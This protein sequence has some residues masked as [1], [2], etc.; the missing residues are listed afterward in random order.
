MHPDT[1]EELDV[2]HVRAGAGWP[3][4]VPTTT[5]AEPGDRVHI[6]AVAP[7]TGELHSIDSD[8]LRHVPESD[9]PGVIVKPRSLTV[10][11]PITLPKHDEA[12][13]RGGAPCN[14][15]Q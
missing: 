7:S 9:P 6:I 11:R 8:V 4:F 10:P 12:I 1:I 3:I 15:P 5:F 13:E 14:S 2:L